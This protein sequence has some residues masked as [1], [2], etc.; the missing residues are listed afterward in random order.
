MAITSLTRN[1]VVG[2]PARG[3]ESHRL[4][5]F[6]EPRK[7]LRC[8]CVPGFV[9]AGAVRSRDCRRNHILP[10]LRRPDVNK[11]I[12][13]SNS[14]AQDF[15]FTAKS[16]KTRKLS[17]RNLPLAEGDLEWAD[18]VTGKP[19]AELLFQGKREK[20]VENFACALE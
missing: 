3:F 10:R 15:A 18:S 17:Q 1:Q 4:R 13:G 11:V 5:L 16:V 20:A 7:T 9:Y 19:K 12:S 6:L 14:S 8:L 2:Q